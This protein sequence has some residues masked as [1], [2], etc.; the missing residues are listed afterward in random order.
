MGKAYVDNGNS[1]ESYATKVMF[2]EN[3]T[4]LDIFEM[5]A[6]IKASPYST[7][8]ERGGTS[9]ARAA[10]VA[11]DTAIFLAST[12]NLAGVLKNVGDAFEVGTAFFSYVN[13]GDKGGVS[14]GGTLWMIDS[15]DEAKKQAS[16][17]FIKFCVNPENQ[18]Y[19]NSITGYFPINVKTQDTDTFKAN[20]E[21]YPQFQTVLDQLHAS[22]PEYVGSLLSV[23]PEERQ[24]V[25]TSSRR[26]CSRG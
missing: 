2:G 8:I 20:I 17:E 7:Y 13:E 11:G 23:F 24:Y 10:I 6:K 16:F 18:A 12:A 21:K 4:I 5:W 3:G 1:R 26:S 9:A 14:T 15:G 25:E 22:G 19:W